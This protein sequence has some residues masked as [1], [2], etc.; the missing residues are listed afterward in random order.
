MMINLRNCSMIAIAAFCIACSPRYDYVITNGYIID[1]N[2][3]AGYHADIAIKDHKIALIG[4]LRKA[5][6][7][8]EIDARGHVVSPGFVNML[9][10]AAGG[11]FRDGRAMSDIKQGVTF[12]VFGEG[13]SLGPKNPS[14][15]PDADY[16]TFGEGMA[17][18]EASGVSVNFG[19]FVGATTIR[20]HELGYDDIAPDEAQLNAM[21]AL[22]EQAMEEGALGLGTSLI[23]PPAYFAKTDEL[24]ALSKAMAPYGG[25][26]ISH[27]RS[28]GKDFIKAFDEL[29]T[30]A[31]EAGVAAEVFHL[32][33][34]G[35]PNWHKLDEV[36]RKIDSARAE[37]MDIA[38]NM[39]TYIA[40]STGVDACLPPWVQDGGKEK[41]LERL[42]DSSIRDQLTDEIID[43]EADY[44]NFYLAAGKPE[45]ILLTGFD[46]D[47]LKHY[48]GMNLGA[49]ADARDQPLP[50][51]I[52][53]LILD[54]GGDIGA[55]FF[56]MS[57]ENVARQIQLPYMTF[58]SDAGAVA[59]E[60]KEL[61]NS[62]HPRAYGNFA[63]LLGKYVREEQLITLEEAIYRLSYLPAQ[64]LQLQE[65][66]RLL[67]GNFADIVIFDA[68][69]IKDKATFDAPHQYA[70]GVQY[71]WVNGKLVL[72]KGEHTGA[73]PGRF[74]P[75]PGYKLNVE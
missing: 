30:I 36:L 57:E 42:K 5:R 23:Y 53:D 19:S 16:F 62:R 38:A 1:G 6:R 44:E 45:N 12:E 15:N 72:K 61:E 64:R 66:G 14:E 60:G 20:I 41:F 27:M 49:I 33:A 74:V 2:G 35:E 13:S 75:G 21:Q 69:E 71:V 46:E 54:N 10:W 39:Y 9:S 55:V 3:T 22:V 34:A 37:N 52:Y 4:D 11:L 65:R 67:P 73:M 32:K 7:K 56:L 29:M 18:L 50:D 70:E 8:E 40:A 51:A 43:P 59:A 17:A 26:Y 24:I 31:T 28:E 25:R 47:S 48:S 58:G 63:R 68:N